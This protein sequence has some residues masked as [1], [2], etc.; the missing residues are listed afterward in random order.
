MRLRPASKPGYAVLFAVVLA[1]APQSA[2]AGFLDFL[3]GSSPDQRAAEPT[4]QAPQT[5][6]FGNPID[7]PPAT[8]TPVSSGRSASY[9]VRT[10]DGKYFPLPAR[11]SMPPAQMCQSF[12]PASTTKIYFGSNIETALGANGER[13]SELQNAFAY[14]KTLKADC[15]CNGRSP[16]GLAPVDLALDT[17]L[18]P[19][20]IVAT[21]DGLVAYTGVSPINGQTAEFAPVATYP[22]LTPELR[23]RLGEMKVAPVS[24][25]I[26]EVRPNSNVEITGTLPAAHTA[27]RSSAPKI[28]MPAT[29]ASLN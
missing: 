3:F 8:V 28:A 5:D 18:R 7:P 20:D 15:T 13:Y 9:C 17:T 2:S 4:R 25:D 11:T 29:R 27:A 23:A 22:G 24:A 1:L 19:G 26:G 6:F 10:C 21:T 16:G 12:C 14:R